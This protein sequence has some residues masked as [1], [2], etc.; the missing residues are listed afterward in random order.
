[1]NKN[2][3]LSLRIGS[4][5]TEPVRPE[6]IEALTEVQVS[7]PSD[8]QGG[9]QLKLTLGKRSVIASQ[10]LPSGYFDPKRRVIVVVTLKG[11]PFVLMD[12][13][14][15]KLDVSP[16][17]EAGASTLTVTGLDLT[18]L[19]DFIDLSGIP[20]PALPPFLVVMAILAK[21][22]PFGVVPVALPSP[23]TLIQ[24]PLERFSS[25]KGTDLSYV[26]FLA[27]RVGHVF[28]LDPGPA[29]GMSVAYWGPEERHGAL[30]PALSVNLD[31]ASNVQSLSFA[32]DGLQREMVVAVFQEPNTK[33]PIPIPI[34]SITLLKPTL[35]RQTAAL[36]K[37]RNLPVA[38][39]DAATGAQLA[40][41]AL[42]GS[43]DAISASG[44]LDVVRYG[45][46]LA[47]RKLVP[48]RGAGDTFDGV[49]YVKNV[50]SNIK[51][52]SFTQSFSLV[53]GGVGSTISRVS[54]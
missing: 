45:H 49:Y 8:G 44:Q 19:M 46:V 39:F 42:A 34:P 11:T 37:T 47:P 33:I 29:Q 13:V 22:A 52:G 54:A 5:T 30:Q 17:E 14:I 38:N 10:L 2:F 50:T 15:T 21:Y 12:G 3:L 41:A 28:Y 35:A 1:M 40:L 53:R 25:H 7:A 6:V 48:V 24:N 20:Y 36:G 31:A 4:V 51:R 9:F 18:A 26:R 43:S 32:Y 27:R 16:S 23:I